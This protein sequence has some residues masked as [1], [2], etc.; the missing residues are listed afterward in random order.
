MFSRYV[1]LE[2]HQ[3]DGSELRWLG[4]LI[5]VLAMTGIRIDALHETKY[6]LVG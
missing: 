5:N 1:L 6:A 2:T 4:R 3:C